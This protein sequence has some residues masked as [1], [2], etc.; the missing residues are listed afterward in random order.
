M[1]DRYTLY[2]VKYIWHNEKN[3]QNQKKHGI[4]FEEASGA[5][6]DPFMHEKYDFMN[7]IGEDRYKVIGSI[8]GFV[9]GKL[10]TVSVTY[11]D[12]FIR[13]FSARY[14]DSKETKEY[15]DAFKE[16]FG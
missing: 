4:S 15:H 2:Q 14:A 8:T 9:Q 11:R 6:E 16:T 3:V 12:E 5:C 1:G 10:V 7:S 13:V